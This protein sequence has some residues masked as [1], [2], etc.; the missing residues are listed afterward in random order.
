MEWVAGLPSPGEDSGV[1]F[2]LWGSLGPNY[3]ETVVSLACNTACPFI[4]NPILTDILTIGLG[5]GVASVCLW[6]HLRKVI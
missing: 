4:L 1:G 3:Q 5:L 2:L 6:P